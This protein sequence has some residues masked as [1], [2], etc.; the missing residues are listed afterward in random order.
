MRLLVHSGSRGRGCGAASSGVGEPAGSWPAA[1]AERPAG[2]AACPSSPSP[3]T[4]ETG[5]LQS[6]AAGNECVNVGVSE[7]RSFLLQRG[8]SVC[9]KNPTDIFPP[10]AATHESNVVLHEVCM[11]SEQSVS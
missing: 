3:C 7:R 2:R 5:S 10:L 1:G 8:Q 11:E 9:T 6:S 4:S